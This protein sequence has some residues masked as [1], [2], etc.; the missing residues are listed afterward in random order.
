MRKIFTLKRFFSTSAAIL[1]VLILN[2]QLSIL[3]LQQAIAA[4]PS[5][6]NYKIQEYNFGAGGSASSSSQNYRMNGM[7]GQVEFGRPFSAS[8]KVGSG[9][10]YTMQASVSA[11]PT[12][13]NPSSNYDRLK[14]ML[15]PGTSPTDVTYAIAISTDNFAADT[16]YIKSD[17][18]IG[19]TLTNADFQTYSAWGGAS[20]AYITGLSQNTTYTI[21]V[22]ARQGNYTESEYSQTAQATTLT[23][24]LTFSVSSDTLTFNNLN[25]SNSYT[26]S[27]KTTVLTTSTNAYNGYIINARS[28]GPLSASGF[29]TIADYTSPNSAPTTWSGLGFGYTTDDSSL[30]GGTVNRFTSSGPKYAGFTTSSPG[31]PV[32]DHAGPVT[33]AISNE[34]FNIS[35]KV[36]TDQNQKAAKYTTTVLYIVVPS[37]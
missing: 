22:K 21:K 37:Y 9:L 14:F 16:R 12:F 19:T 28:T 8:F 17:N 31:D 18:T 10:T 34:N 35:Y 15:N 11:A 27:S 23:P 3:N 6:I 30:T 24:S 5:S 1:M 20:G 29:G 32:A 13:T 4:N 25:A 26:D 36:V 2:S 7:A 33:T